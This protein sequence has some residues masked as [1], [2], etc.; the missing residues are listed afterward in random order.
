MKRTDLM[1]EHAITYLQTPGTGIVEKD[2]KEKD[3]FVVA[4]EYDNYA[5]S[6]GT[7]LVQMGAKTATYFYEA[8]EPNSNQPKHKIPDAILAI[9]KASY[10]GMFERNARLSQAL[11]N[12]KG[13]TLYSLSLKIMDAAIALKIALRTYKIIEDE[14]DK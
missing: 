5:A 10:P 1:T 14:Q 12:K 4:K 9:L 7:S 11:Q 8:A 3:V 13:E 2:K 6:F